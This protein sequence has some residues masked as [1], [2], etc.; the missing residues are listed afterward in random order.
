MTGNPYEAPA[1]E[2][3]PQEPA[4]DPA[5]RPRLW[6]GGW[7]LAVIA[8]VAWVVPGGNM[9]TTLITGISGYTLVVRRDRRA[10]APL[11]FGLTGMILFHLTRQF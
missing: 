11:I 9:I 1:A 10:I 2:I 8:L 4:H 6:A 3:A 7:P 5:T